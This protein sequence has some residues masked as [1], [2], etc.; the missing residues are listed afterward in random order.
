MDLE[1]DPVKRTSN[2]DKHRVDFEDAR[3]FEFSSALAWEDERKDYGETRW[4]A[5]GL[6]DNRLHVICF[7]QV[8]AGIRVISLRKANKREVNIYANQ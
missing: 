5:I 4:V 1:Y 2:L 7:T 3:R 8:I 6:L